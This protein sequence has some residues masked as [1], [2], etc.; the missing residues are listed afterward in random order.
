MF[1]DFVNAMLLLGG[2]IGDLVW[3]SFLD[4]YGGV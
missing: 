4:I 3:V 1:Y 2:D